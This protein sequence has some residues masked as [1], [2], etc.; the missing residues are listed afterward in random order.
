MGDFQREV[1]VAVMSYLKLPRNRKN[2]EYSKKLL[3]FIRLDINPILR[4]LPQFL[5]AKDQWYRPWLLGHVKLT[6]AVPRVIFF[7]QA[8][9]YY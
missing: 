8:S 9:K 6:Y 3:T 1:D 4:V 7:L 5:S 2:I